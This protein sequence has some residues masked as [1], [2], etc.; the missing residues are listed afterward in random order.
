MLSQFPLDAAPIHHPHASR[1]GRLISKTDDVK[2]T[3]QKSFQAVKSSLAY[4]DCRRP[5]GPDS[6]TVARR[7]GEFTHLS[8]AFRIRKRSQH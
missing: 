2:F 7:R 4:I 6:A 1:W 5:G 8:S 3:G